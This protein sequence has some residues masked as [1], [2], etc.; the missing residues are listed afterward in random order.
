MATDS[1]S[2]TNHDHRRV[3]IIV[4][5]SSGMGRATARAFAVAGLRLVVAARSGDRLA[6]LTAELTDAGADVAA[7]R[8][9]ATVR[10]D[11]NEVVRS[12][13]ARY[14]RV[15]ALVNCVGVNIPRR[16][17]DE[18]TGESWRSMIDGNL[19]AAFNLTQAILPVFRA[20]HDGLIVH[21]AS[22]SARTADRSGVAYQAAKA[23]VAALAHG[24][25]VEERANGVRTTVIYPGLTDTD[26][27]LQRPV[28]P[29]RAELD[30]AIQPQDVAAACLFVVQ[31]PARAHVPDL[32]LYPADP[33][34]QGAGKV[35]TAGAG[36]A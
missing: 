34:E 25:M 6:S 7:V 31:L 5:A 20:Q 23:G 8:A 4:G 11:A 16:R 12:A 10:S 29:S 24:T 9:D 28:P 36:D 14:G 19:T 26:F 27:I 17:V 30:R 15:D 22:S 18:L 3:A 32:L 33:L 35:P 13:M 2:S 1:E 21:I